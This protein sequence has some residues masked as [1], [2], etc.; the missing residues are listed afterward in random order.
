MPSYYLE[1]KREHIPVTTNNSFLNRKENTTSS[2]ILFSGTTASYLRDP[3]WQKLLQLKIWH[4]WNW[5]SFKKIFFKCF[6]FSNTVLVGLEM[7]DQNIIQKF[8]IHPF[9]RCDTVLF[10][11]S[12]M[13]KTP[14]TQ[15]LTFVE[16]NVV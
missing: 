16:L 4:L 14:P 13:A 6:P 12:W 2:S 7:I 10:E 8:T 15:N 1:A 5:T 3:K 9:F 11:R